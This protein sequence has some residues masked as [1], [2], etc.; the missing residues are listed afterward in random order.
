MVSAIASWKNVFWWAIYCSHNESFPCASANTIDLI[1]FSMRSVKK[2]LNIQVI[3]TKHRFFLPVIYS[4]IKELFEHWSKIHP[5]RSIGFQICWQ[6][7]PHML[8]TANILFIITQNDKLC[9]G[10]VCHLA[11]CSWKLVSVDTSVTV[12]YYFTHV[13][14]Y[15]RGI[16]Y[17]YQINSYWFHCKLFHQYDHKILA[18]PGWCVMCVLNM[19]PHGSK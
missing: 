19:L 14:K 8:T 6:I 16:L 1:V 13:S 3:Q 4:Y 9:C 5:C 10:F 18:M 7:V 11:S 12:A 2:V 17:T 15:I